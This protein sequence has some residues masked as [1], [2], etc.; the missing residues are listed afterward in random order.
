MTQLRVA[1]HLSHSN[2]IYFKWSY[3]IVWRTH[4]VYTLIVVLYLPKTKLIKTVENKNAT[5]LEWEGLM[6]II[7]EINSSYICIAYCLMSVIIRM[8]VHEMWIMFQLFTQQISINMKHTHVD[9][10]NDSATSM[11]SIG[12]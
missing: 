1:F 10:Q 5:K 3:Y 7:D 6:G 2:D 11:V 8:Y 12:R 9:A 4:I